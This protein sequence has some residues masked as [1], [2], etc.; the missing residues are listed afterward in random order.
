MDPIK[1]QSKIILAK[2]ET[3][4]G[5][6][7]VPTGA[8]NAMLMKDVEFRPMEGEDVSRALERPSLGAQEEFPVALRAMLT[9]SVELVGSGTAGT[10]PAWGPLMRACGI[11]ETV[12]VGVDVEYTPISDGHESCSL[13][14][15]IGPTRHIMLGTRGNVEF[16]VNAQGIPVAKFSLTGLFVTPSD[17]ARPTPDLSLF[18][19]PQVATDANTP[20]FTVG[21]TSFVLRELGFNIGNDVQPRLLIGRESIEIVDRAES[22]S[23]TVEAVP[24]ATY[25]PYA[26]AAA[27]TRQAVVLTH[28][29]AAG[30]ITTFSWPT[31]AQKRLSGFQQNQNIVEWPLVLTPLQTD[32][33]DQW[34]ITLT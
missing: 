29:T 27:R 26:I 22:L 6:D 3:V 32:G 14:F 4:Y 12:S 25:N 13:Y 20:V 1:W 24:L 11:A 15:H 19:L 21:G 5:T 23:A 18:E 17:Q 7:S 30:G 34:A 33:D 28:G 8:A 10:A 9:G 16:T 2:M 31:C